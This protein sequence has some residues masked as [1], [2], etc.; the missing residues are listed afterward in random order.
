MKL[1][2]YKI[3]ADT[4]VGFALGERLVPLGA[5]FRA[6]GLGAAPPTML[7]LIEGGAAGL[8]ALA[9]AYVAAT[10]VTEAHRQS[11]VEWLPPVRGYKILAVAINNSGVAKLASV[12][13][14]HPP[15]FMKAGSSL[16]GHGQKLVIRPDYGL[17]HPEAELAVVIGQH[18]KNLTAETALDAVF[19]YTIINDITSITM[20]S[21]DTYVFPAPKSGPT[22][23]GFEWGDMQLTYHARSKS[24]DGF[25][26]M[27]PWIVTRDEIANPNRLAVKVFMAEEEVTADN[28]ANLR[29]SVQEVLVWASRYFT[30]E[31]GDVI[32]L[33]TAAAGRYSLRELDLQVW[34][35]PLAIEI[36]GI[37]RISN[38]IERID[39]DGRRVSARAA[40]PNNVWP[41]RY[42]AKKV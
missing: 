35:G 31:P 22:P 12:V 37:G 38:P 17:T 16:I 21:E 3:G 27:G 20:K 10:S 6:A 40:D 26:P 34:D 1:A 13:A 39:L 11:D 15:F 36:E 5:A 4:Q 42:A 9:K 30:L 19:G 41:P 18:C 32:Q 28:T 33:G 23:P 2:T 8:A 7:A 29:Y 25:G 14:K 24:T